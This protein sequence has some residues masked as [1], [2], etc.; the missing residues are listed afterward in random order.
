MLCNQLQE[1]IDWQIGLSATEH[2]YAKEI[3][4]YEVWQIY[5]RLKNRNSNVIIIHYDYRPI[6]KCNFSLFLKHDLMYLTSIR[7]I[8]AP[9]T[10]FSSFF[11][12][13]II[14]IKFNGKVSLSA[15]LFWQFSL[16][17]L[18]LDY[19]WKYVFCHTEEC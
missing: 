16:F 1:K 8:I 18:F 17:V 10:F 12:G 7:S 5:T 13:M 19:Y 15:T 14:Y 11:T 6:C 9:P 2:E 3:G 4:L